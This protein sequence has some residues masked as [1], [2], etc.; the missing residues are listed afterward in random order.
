MLSGKIILYTYQKEL[1]NGYPIKIRLTNGKLK[2]S[3][4]INTGYYAKK[5]N[6]YPDRKHPQY[7]N[8]V[9]DFLTWEKKLIELLPVANR[10]QWTLEKLVTQFKSH[11]E[12]LDFEKFIETL[13]VKYRTK[14]AYYTAIKSFPNFN[15]DI[16]KYDVQR[17]LNTLTISNNSK[18]VYIR[19]L[20]ALFNK[21]IQQGFIDA[22]NPFNKALLPYTKT[23]NT[24][25]NTED[26]IKIKEAEHTGEAKKYK[27]YYLLMFYLGGILPID[28]V[29]LRYDKHIIGNR[30]EF[31]R[32]K[33]GTNEFVS[34]ILVDE[35]K[36]ILKQYDC[37][38]YL[39]PIYKSNY[40]TVISN[41]TSRFPGYCK[42][43]NLTRPP[44]A[45][46]ARSSFINRAQELLIDERI[47]M[48][49]VGHA[50]KGTHSIYP[51]DISNKIKDEAFLKIV[52]LKP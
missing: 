17:W 46:S 28:L 7:S 43:L 36:E 44:I 52:N 1:K 18:N 21:A 3:K 49:I 14:Q 31:T 6:G 37:Y 39:V 24:G 27:D 32:F 12:H 35:A 4:Y 33:G 47:S 9:V 25:L 22:E 23:K 51:D 50:R 8:L 42:D 30:I 45:K 34:N 19:S 5:W 48:A 40:N 20:K 38:P 13:N 15:S 10:K 26:L 16:D 11:G 2:K 41:F 29:N